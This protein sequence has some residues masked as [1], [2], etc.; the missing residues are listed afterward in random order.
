[1][2]RTLRLTLSAAVLALVVLALLVVAGCGSSGGTGGNTGNT[3]GSGGT[4]SGGGT[5][6]TIANFAFSPAS[7]EVKVGDTVTWTN[8]DSAVHDV[9]GDGGI[10]SGKLNQGDTYAKKFDAAGSFAYKCAIHPSMTGT[11]VVK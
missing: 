7:L 3:G 9:Q 4:T 1:M 10:S 8:E 5:D 6:V 2:E 11:I